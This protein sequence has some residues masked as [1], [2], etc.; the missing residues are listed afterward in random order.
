MFKPFFPSLSRTKASE[1]KAPTRK[2]PKVVKSHK[3]KQTGPI[4]NCVGCG[5]DWW[6]DCVPVP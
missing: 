1:V 4:G 3:T 2:L 6:C 5:G